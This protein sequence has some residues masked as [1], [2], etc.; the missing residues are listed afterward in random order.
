MT[1]YNALQIL[2]TKGKDYEWE[3]ETY[4]VVRASVPGR[5]WA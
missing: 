1:G 5:R 3:H 4:M 2:F